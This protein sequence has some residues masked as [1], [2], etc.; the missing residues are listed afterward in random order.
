MSQTLG[1]MGAVIQRTQRFD[2]RISNIK[3]L[4]GDLFAVDNPSVFAQ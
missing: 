3:I 1:M 4:P 2:M